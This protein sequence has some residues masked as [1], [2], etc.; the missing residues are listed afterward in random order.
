MRE[1]TREE[2]NRGRRKE[3]KKEE[4]TAGKSDSGEL[5]CRRRAFGGEGLCSSSSF[6][7]SSPQLQLRWR[8][9]K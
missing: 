4:V 8:P 3:R 9:R 2:R 1:R 7:L 5:L 6:D